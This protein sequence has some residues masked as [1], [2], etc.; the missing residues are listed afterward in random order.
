[1]TLLIYGATGY[2]GD[3]IAREA[4]ARGYRPVLAGRNA[5]TVAALAGPLGLAHRGF[6]LAE[7]RALDAGLDGVT[8]VLHCAG[9]FS[10]TAA[11]M[12]AACLRRGAHYLDITGEIEVFE[13]LRARDAEARAAGVMLLPGVG[14]DVVPSDCLAA[15]LKRRLPGATH[16]ALALLPSGRVSR[17]TAATMVEHAH[18]GGLVRR[19]GALT[20]VPS[21]WKTR[22]AD[23]G[24]GERT[25]ITIPWG[26][27]STAY[28]STGIPNVAVY[29]SAPLVSSVALRAGRFLA[30]VLRS[31]AVK[32]WLQRRIRRG[33]PGPTAEERARGRTVIWGEVTDGAGRRAASRLVGPE[34][35]EMTVRTALAVVEK[36]LAG[37]APPGFQTPSRAY[38]PDFVLGV[39]GVSR[40]D[41]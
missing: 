11:P 15:H 5:A 20:P 8:A 19:E 30:P 32:S 17:G 10:G 26:D 7:E 39:P 33:P 38:G 12:A 27:V 25:V 24:R 16:L 22:R 9:P 21:G 4:A 13:R 41:L 37:E 14:F 31:R 1:M 36:V 23:F 18:R 40:E 28:Y 3:L 34:G 6:S 35:Y 29:V 2:T